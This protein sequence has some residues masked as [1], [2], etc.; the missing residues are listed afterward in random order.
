M[1][2]LI[3]HPLAGSYR[4]QDGDRDEVFC[5]V[6]DELGAAAARGAWNPPYAE[7]H[8]SVDYNC[9]LAPVFDSEHR[10]A[11]SI[12]WPIR[13]IAEGSLIVAEIRGHGV[14]VQRSESAENPSELAASLLETGSSNREILDYALRPAL[15]R[16]MRDS[17]PAT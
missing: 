5:F 8:P 15:E 6:P 1:S 4:V 7:P 2:T 10:L 14:D 12:L 3:G 11:F 13:A 17:K 9:A 16:A